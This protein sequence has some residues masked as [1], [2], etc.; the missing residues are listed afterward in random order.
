M[1]KDGQM[2]YH[3]IRAG[4]E[5][6]EPG[7]L[8]RIQNRDSSFFRHQDTVSGTEKMVLHERSQITGWTVVADLPLNNLIGGLITQRNYSLAAAAVLMIIALALVGGFSL[9]LTRPLS[10]LQKLMARV[11]RGFCASYQREP[12]PQQ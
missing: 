10:M 3:R 11:E 7:L 8:T 1:G 12:V 4:S 2:I 6:I 5:L 9:S